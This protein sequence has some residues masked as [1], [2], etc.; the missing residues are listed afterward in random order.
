MSLEL[1]P[2]RRALAGT[3]V[4]MACACGAGNSSAKLMTMA[5][6]PMTAKL[7]HSLLLLVGMALIFSAFWQ[8][9]RRAAGIAAVAFVTLGV[10]A[11]L[12]P[13]MMMS[14]SKLPWHGMQLVGAALYLIS[15]AALAYAFFL[16]FPSPRPGATATALAG[17][18][19]ATGCNC[20]MVTGAI[21]GLAVTAGGSKAVFLS[22][23]T[24]FFSGLAL[25]A[26]GL[27]FLRGVRPIPWLI[28]GAV[29]TRWGGNALKY[30]GDWMVGEVNLRF[31][32]GYMIYLIGAGLIMT[33][34]AVAYEPQRLRGNEEE[35]GIV[36]SP[37]LQS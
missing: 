35:S 14:A 37:A 21:A 15:S 6:M 2:G 32:P 29:I 1:T 17:T 20:C 30:L 5:G 18:A 34:W 25:A 23:P 7:P 31:I 3:T 26:V 33:A 19:V 10:A 13:P 11:I 16:A 24:V 28:A 36:A 4:M 12:T 27:S 8:I 22:N 9:H